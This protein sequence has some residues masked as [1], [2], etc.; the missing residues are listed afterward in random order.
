MTTPQQGPEVNQFQAPS[1]PLPPQGGADLG[2]VIPPPAR[3]SATR[4]VAIGAGMLMVLAG[5]FLL[6]W[7]PGLHT[8][9]AL[10]AET[11]GAGVAL[12]RVQIV[13]PVVIASDR[14]LSLP[15]SMVPLEETVLYPRSS[16]FVKR[17]AVDL[18]DKVH[19]GDLL[20]E[21]DTPDIDQQL[22][23]A[24]AQLAQADAGLN[25]A[26]ANANF[27]RDNLARYQQLLPAGLVSQQDFDKQKSQAE[28]DQASIA[29]AAATIA[30][31]RANV[32]LLTQLK[33]FGRIVAPF[34]GTITARTIERGMLVAPGTATPLYKIS[35]LDPVRVLVQVPQDVAPSVRVGLAATVTVR[36]FA[37][38]TFLGK[39]ERAAGALDPATRT[40]LTEVR[41][42]NPQG[43]LL[44]G[45]YAQVALTLPTPHRVLSVPATAVLNDAGGVRVAVVG[46][47]DVVHLAP[48]VIERDTGATIELASGL[49]PGDRVVKLP[50]ADLTEGRVIEVAP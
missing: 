32:Q 25:Q 33:A 16:G 43:E 45:M 22:A 13:A 38:R 12:L 10:E 30:S 18:G 14:S 4:A 19:E 42:P 49:E 8:R 15:G 23:Q 47:G 26:R 48:V 24:R 21:I 9:A 5:A 36:E 50:S 31:Q 1:A 39:V 46:P 37:G 3:L 7:L 17:W 20:A 29:V 34:S 40:M 27:S 41:V 11:K 35:A 2:F 6:R 44:T 28:V